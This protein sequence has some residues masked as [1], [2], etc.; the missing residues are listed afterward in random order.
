MNE[1]NIYSACP[2]CGATEI[3]PSVKASCAN[4]RLYK[5]QLS[6]DIIW[7]SC[8]SCDHLFTEGYFTEEA[9]RVIFS[10]TNDIQVV[11]ADLERQR[12]IFARIVE[13]VGQYH[14]EQNGR[15]LDVGFGNGS[16]LYTADEYG[17]KTVGIDLRKINVVQMNERGFEA[18]CVELETYTP[19]SP[20]HVISM[21]D[22]LEHMPYP[23]QVLSKV[24]EMM[25]DSGVLFLSM[26]NKDAYVWRALTEKGANPYWGEIEHYHNF[27]RRR[28]YQLLQECG[29][30]PIQY[31]VSERY[32]VC[33]E[34]IARKSPA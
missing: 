11:D 16:M 29:F 7:K 1:R 12:H 23:K 17:Y 32:R 15:W 4:H 28:L 25:H 21:A 31:G 18:H 13:K 27:G 8:S 24:R 10:D 5:P 2:L 30:E 19:T 22:V 6:P 33:M 9:L 14:T 3:V 34:V 20:F 26:P